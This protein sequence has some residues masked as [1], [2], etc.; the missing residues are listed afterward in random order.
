[1]AELVA[2]RNGEIVSHQSDYVLI[3]TVE[4]KV[5]AFGVCQC[6]RGT[7]VFRPSPF[8]SKASALIVSSR[9]ADANDVSVIYVDA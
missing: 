3:R 6:P 4:G 9:W 7:R 8:D 1:M 2:I 5:V